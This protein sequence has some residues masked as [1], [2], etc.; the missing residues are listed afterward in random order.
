MGNGKSG[1]RGGVLMG[2]LL[3]MLTLVVIAAVVGIRIAQSVEVEKTETKDGATVSIKTPA[4]DFNIRAHDSRLPPDM[5]LY[6]TAKVIKGSGGAE[7]QWS[8][9]DGRNDKDFRVAGAEM[10]TGDSV[11]KVFD[12]Y[13]DKL[14]SWIVK[15]E[16]NGQ[17]TLE[18]APGARGLEPRRFVAIRGKSDGTHIGV[19]TIGAPESN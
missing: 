9:P 19:A 8:S 11:D 12:Y 15:R 18:E 17:I 2:V 13:H 10:L 7:F 14:P 5:P 4:G 1:R 6:P 16:N 3:T